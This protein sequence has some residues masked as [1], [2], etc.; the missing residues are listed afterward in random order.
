VAQRGLANPDE[1][2]A[3]ASDYLRLFAL[4]AFAFMWARAAKVSLPK[5]SGE[6]AWFYKGKLAAARFF[7]S[8]ILPQTSS[9]LTVISAGAKPVMALE[10]E[11]F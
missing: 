6:E 9:L 1:A 5:A 2:G 8:R 10:A 3:A 7:M 11:A 4:T